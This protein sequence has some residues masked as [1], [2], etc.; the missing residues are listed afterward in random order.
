MLDSIPASFAASHPASVPDTGVVNGLVPVTFS[1][2]THSAFVADVVSPR[3]L[4]SVALGDDD[5]NRYIVVGIGTYR[6]GVTGVTLDGN[7][8]TELLNPGWIGRLNGISLW[9]LAYPTGTSKDIVVSLD[10]QNGWTT[11]HVA[12]LIGTAGVIRDSFSGDGS[13]W[14]HGLTVKNGDCVVLV[15]ANVGTNHTFTPLN[16]T[17]DADV[18]AASFSDRTGFAHHECLVDE[19]RSVEHSAGVIDTDWVNGAVVLQPK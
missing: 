10:A 9:G 13:A 12:R 3:T 2:L 17:E 5:P 19:T 16:L 18:A 14:P 11:V 15:S 8:M 7:A 6:R 1:Y 4:S